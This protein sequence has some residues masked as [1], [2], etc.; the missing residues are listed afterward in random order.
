MHQPFP[1]LK[2]RGELYDLPPIPKRGHIMA[3]TEF[4]KAVRK[5]RLDS[6]DTL[7]TMAKSLGITPAFLSAIEHGKNKIPP[8]LV[9]RIEA[10]LKNQGIEVKNLMKLADLSNQHIPLKGLSEQHQQLLLRLA[11]TSYSKSDLDNIELFLNT[12]NN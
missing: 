10:L 9:V 12:I 8:H 1:H 2:P 3:L 6:G 11:H 5:A 4:G 7:K